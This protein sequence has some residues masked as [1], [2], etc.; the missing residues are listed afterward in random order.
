MN[1]D[2]IA[3]KHDI[4][5]V[6]N[7]ACE[8]HAKATSTYAALASMAD[9]VSDTQNIHTAYQNCLTHYTK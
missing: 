9:S 5:F 2:L 8:A 3:T 4:D 1:D 7:V 6:G